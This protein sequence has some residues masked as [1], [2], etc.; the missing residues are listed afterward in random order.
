[1]PIKFECEVIQVQAKKTGLDKEFK[2]VLIT[3]DE[4]VL[5]LQDYIAKDTVKIEVND[6]K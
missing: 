3:D 5:K 4:H 6:G 1:M 2:L